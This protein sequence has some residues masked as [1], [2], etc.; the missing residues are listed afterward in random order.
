MS[1]ITT[2][3]TKFPIIKND[4]IRDILFLVGMSLIVFVE[5]MTTTMFEE[6]LQLYMFLKIVAVVFIVIKAILFDSWTIKSS[7]LFCFFF[8]VSFFVKYCSTYSDCFFWTLLLW[9]ARDIS[10]RKILKCH[11]FVV[12]SIVLC[13]FVASSFGLIESLKYFTNRGI[14]N[15][16]GICYPTDFAA[17]IFFLML[18]IFYLYEDRLKWWMYSFGLV[19]AYIVYKYTYARLDCICM[20]ILSV[21][22]MTVSIVSPYL[23]G[24]A[25]IVRIVLCFA[26]IPLALLCIILSY[27]YNPEV[28]WMRELNSIFSSRLA[29]GREAFNRLKVTPFGQFFLMVGSGGSTEYRADYFFLDSSYLYVLFRY[30]V[31]FTIL[32]LSSF[33][34]SALKRKS[35]LF[36]IVT[37][38]VIAINATTAHHLTHVQYNPFFM[39]LFAFFPEKQNQ[40][41]EKRVLS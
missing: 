31:V 26:I 21:L 24:K 7:I 14:R 2:E 5:T 18:S 34:S 37:I 4:K 38:L 28:S 12:F 41:E 9:G 6:K 11:T 19:I 39:A 3:E 25:N 30:G 29:L 17:Y 40:V 8:I 13:A 10:F 36:F 35:D 20:T 27:C 1:F 32:L 22:F 23:K 33:V 15:S 16:F